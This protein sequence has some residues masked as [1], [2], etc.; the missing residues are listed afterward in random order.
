MA[1]ALPGLMGPPPPPGP[2]GLS[3]RPGH[4]GA[5]TG[6]T[7][8]MVR[9]VSDE[10]DL[11][12]AGGG[13]E[14]LGPKDTDISPFQM[15]FAMAGDSLDTTSEMDCTQV[16]DIRDLVNPDLGVGEREI[17]TRDVVS[18]VVL[19]WDTR[20]DPNW[21]V[22][23]PPIFHD[24]VN[25][26]MSFIREEDLACGSVLKWT[27]LW[28][29]VGLLG[30]SARDTALLTEYREVLESQYMGSTKFTIFP[31][32]G[33][34]RKGC[35]SILLRECYRHF[36]I[37]QLPKELLRRS[38]KL[39]GGL[40]VTHTK[41]YKA[42]DRSRNGAS[43]EGW[44]LVLLQ[45]TKEF[46]SSLEQFEEDHRFPLGSDRVI[47]RG[48]KRRPG[49]GQS[50][51]QRQDQRQSHSNRTGKNKTYDRDYPNNN[52]DNSSSRRG[53]EQGTSGTARGSSNASTWGTTPRKQ[54]HN[55]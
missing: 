4:S 15:E 22:P 26:V 27:N 40:K 44:T 31:R 30:L 53:D 1:L 21:T 9:H 6:F 25:R 38:K 45:G 2:P 43:K 11:R 19:K 36:N 37:A 16:L 50:R 8:E 42:G 13:E 39:R 32:D 35:L 29:K 18:Y 3:V 28:G 17:R 12:C 46:M 5:A 14:F 20:I 33:L 41:T 52:K 23:D 34:E 10:V 7:A 55:Q 49:Q 24:L 54:G 51:P 48:G 47:V